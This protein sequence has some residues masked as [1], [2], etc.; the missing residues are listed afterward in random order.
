MNIV[1]IDLGTT[2]LKLSVVSINEKEARLQVLDSITIRITG[3]TPTPKA[4][5]H[6]PNEIKKTLFSMIKYFASKFKIEVVTASTYLF[7]TIVVNKDF[8]PLTNIITWLDERASKYVPILKDY[9]IELYRR[10]GC[11]PVHIY[12]LPKLLWLKHEHP[13]TIAKESLILDAKSLISGWFLGYPVTDLSTASGTYQMLNINTLSWDPLALSIADIEE[14][15]LPELREAYYVDYISEGIAREL[16]LEQ[17]TPFVLGLYDGGSMIYGLSIGKKD[18]AVV[19][20]GT[21]AMLRTIIDKPIVDFSHH[22]RFQTYYLADKLWLS[23]GAINNAGVVVEFLAKLFN[24]DISTVG[25]ILDD[26]PLNPDRT[27]LTI[28][29]L[30]RER[31]PTLPEEIGLT[32]YGITSENMFN[33]I[34]WSSIEGILML[35]NMI[36]ESL[37][38]NSIHYEYVMVGGGLAR[39][40]GVVKVLASIL[41]KKV[42][43]VKGIEASHLGCSL[44]VL[45]A[46]SDTD[47]LKAFETSLL[48]NTTYIEPCGL[49][50]KAYR[51][52]YSKFKKILFLLTSFST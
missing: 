22:M 10:T 5:E 49:L 45:K 2:N 18:I 42:G 37:L 48:K 35:L 13:N 43:L 32:I 9:A 29:L 34:L 46:L 30:Y 27:P 16:G 20:L 36:D 52:K 3:Y 24:V 33:H 7:A 28:P 11:P 51:E 4:Y 26:D 6:I 44:M 40:R 50:S 19:N 41:N 25:R 17:K 23:G 1:T 31:L 15:Q 14:N 12:T 21:S 38:E 39:Y 8:N 47:L